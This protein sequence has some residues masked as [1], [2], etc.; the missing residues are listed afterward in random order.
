MEDVVPI[1]TA[2]NDDV[3]TMVMP[4]SITGQ[5]AITLAFAIP[6]LRL[7][8]VVAMPWSVART[9]VLFYQ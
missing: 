5:R 9:F 2:M 6:Y 3:M 7:S 8:T 4:S 1:E